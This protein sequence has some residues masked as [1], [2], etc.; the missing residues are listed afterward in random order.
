[1]A[2]TLGELKIKLNYSLGTASTSLNTN[3]RREYAIN[4][5]IEKIIEQ[6]DMPQ[7]TISSTLSFTSGVADLPSDFL[8]PLLLITDKKR[9]ERIDFDAFLRDISNTYTIQYDTAN[10]KEVVKVYPADTTSL[11]LWYIQQPAQLSSDS[12][13]T[14]FPTYWDDAIVEYA[15]ALLLQFNRQYDEY[16]VKLQSA[17]DMLAKAWQNERQR[18]TGKEHQRLTSVFSTNSLLGNYQSIYTRT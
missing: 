16:T 12:D 7:Y 6:Y 17:E 13:T 4:R 14:R 15:A 5:A 10:S 1:M 18:I 8:R 2:S 3:E 9:Y 11:D